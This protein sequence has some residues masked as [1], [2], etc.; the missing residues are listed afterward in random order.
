MGY[1]KIDDRVFEEIAERMKPR[2]T[3]LLMFIMRAAND[4]G[5]S[6]YAHK[7]LA[8]KLNVSVNTIK[9]AVKELKEAGYITVSG[10]GKNGKSCLYGSQI[11]PT[12]RQN[13]ATQV[14]KFSLLRTTQ[15]EGK[16]NKEVNAFGFIPDS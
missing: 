7:T 12:P 3:L 11:L 5:Q 15:V 8:R 6:W 4:K 13:L 14:G 10:D 2:S 1:F 16:Q 9:A